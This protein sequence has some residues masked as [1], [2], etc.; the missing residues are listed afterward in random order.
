MSVAVPEKPRTF[1]MV[2]QWHVSCLWFAYNMMW[3]ALLGI[4]IPNQVEAIVGA[5]H[6]EDWTGRISGLGALVALVI[7]PIAGALSDRCRNPIGRRRPFLLAG[8]LINCF[9]LLCMAFQGKGSSVWIYILAFAGVQLGCNWWGGPYAGLIPDV[10]PPEQVGRASGMQ[11]VMTATGFLSGALMAGAIIRPSFYWP[12]YLIVAAVL[13]VMLG[14]TWRG[15]REK[16]NTRDEPPFNLGRFLRSLWIDPKEHRDFYWVLITRALVTMGSYSIFSFF[17]FFLGDIIMRRSPAQDSSYLLATIMGLGI[18]SSIIAGMLSD[19][20]GRKPLVYISGGAMA[21]VCA[22]YAGLSLRSPSSME[23][24]WIATLV[25]GGLFGIGNG[26]Y[27]AVDWALAVDVLPGGEDA[28]KDMG[29]WHVALVLPQ[30]VAPVISGLLLSYFKAQSELRMGY[31]LVFG[32][33]A[34]WFILGTVFVRQIRGV[35]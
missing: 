12:I 6:K 30:V 32:V 20:I 1:T 27:Q 7:T 28:A 8:I 35:R 9:F 25:A 2:D 19:R 34:V 10:V 5:A 24:A 15:V 21:L 17:Q 26:A 31:T 22:T 4:V 3:G 33:A 14:I 23:V 16:P 11:A 18:P 29:I 13:F